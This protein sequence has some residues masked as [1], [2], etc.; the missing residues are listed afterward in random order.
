LFWDRARGRKRCPNCWY[1][2][3]QAA[4]QSPLR[5]TECGYEAKNERKLFRTRW[6][7]RWAF[8]CLIP[9]LAAAFL[10]V[11][12]KVQR[13]GWGSIMP[14][15][16]LVLGLQMQKNDWAFQCLERRLANEQAAA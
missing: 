10:F 14:T 7:W 13:D 9:L 15:T 2:M 16:F 8:V 12:P 4:P 5:C 6:R 1:D 3:S 11:Q